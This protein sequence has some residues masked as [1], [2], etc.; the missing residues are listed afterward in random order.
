MVQCLTYQHLAPVHAC[1]LSDIQ[2]NIQSCHL[3]NYNVHAHF[4]SQIARI[5]KISLRLGIRFGKVPFGVMK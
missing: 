4:R 5:V 3:P 2:M 1:T